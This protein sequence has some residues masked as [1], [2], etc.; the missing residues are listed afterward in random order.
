M[1]TYYRCIWI[2]HQ[3]ISDSRNYGRF[4]FKVIDITVYF[5]LLDMH[6]TIDKNMNSVLGFS[7]LMEM[8]A[9]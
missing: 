2:S 4:I 7:F 8:L 5:K 3:L 6:V 9:L 1:S